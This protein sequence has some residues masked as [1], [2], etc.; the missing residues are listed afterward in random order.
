MRSDLA[1][2]DLFLNSWNGFSLLRP[3]RLASPDHEFFTDA[4][5]AYGCGM[6]WGDQWIQLKWP[7]PYMDHP[8]AP[9]ELIPIVMACILWGQTWQG[10][11]VHVHFDNEAVVAV[12]N[13]S[14][15]RDSQLMHLARCLFFVLDAYHI[16]GVLNT[17]V[18]AI[19]RDNLSFLFSKVPSAEPRLTLVPLDLVELLVTLQPDWIEPT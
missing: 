6:I 1:W 19:S 9:K 15:S 8:I 4:S 16:P 5:G 10:K 3:H 2:W 7:Q 12:V 11:V 14:Y 18:D 17:V 13:S